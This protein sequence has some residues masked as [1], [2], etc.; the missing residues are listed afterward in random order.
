MSN[1]SRK[2]NLFDEFF[3]TPFF[4]L[5]RSI[6]RTDLKEEADRYLLDIEMPGFHKEDIKVS[7]EDGYLTVEAVHNKNNEENNNDY[8]CKERYFGE[9]KRSYYLGNVDENQINANLTN[10]ILTISVKKLEKLENKKYIS[11]E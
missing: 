11:I 7:L 8:V 4:K 1:L 10:G 2:L 5:D 9:M 3:N 6:M